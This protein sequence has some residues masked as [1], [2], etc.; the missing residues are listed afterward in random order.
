MFR[1]RGEKII[2]CLQ[3][4][5]T[6]DKKQQ[7]GKGDYVLKNVHPTPSTS[8]TPNQPEY[9]EDFDFSLKIVSKF[10]SASTSM[11]IDE[12]LKKNEDLLTAPDIVDLSNMNHDVGLEPSVTN[13]PKIITDDFLEGS[14]P[15]NLTGDSLTTDISDSQ[16]GFVCSHCDVVFSKK[17]VMRRHIID[18]HLQTE[19]SSKEE[20]ITDSAENSAQNHKKKKKRKNENRATTEKKRRERKELRIAGKAYTSVKGKL[21]QER[22][23]EEFTC[24]RCCQFKCSSSF[25]NEEKDNLFFSF[26]KVGAEDKSQDLQIQYLVD[27]IEEVEPKRRFE[28]QNQSRKKRT[29]KY[30]LEKGKQR[31]LVCRQFFLSVFG[32]TENFVS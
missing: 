30:Y 28:D 22:K 29:L 5:E 6:A 8:S 24:P 14:L 4:S 13:L 23:R 10:L 27:R 7:E 9:D 2:N 18:V 1:S 31:V 32:I 20:N 16:N 17:N 12:C 21:L 26:W 19:V 11:L 25:S 15:H 3:K